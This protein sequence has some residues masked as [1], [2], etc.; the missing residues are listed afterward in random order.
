MCAPEDFVVERPEVFTMCLEIVRDVCE[1]K[2]TAEDLDR[3][4]KHPIVVSVNEYLNSGESRQ[5]TS[6]D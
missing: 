4:V 1:S 5:A 6:S 3:Q 2:D